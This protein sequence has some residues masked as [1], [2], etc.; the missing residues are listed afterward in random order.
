MCEPDKL[1]FDDDCGDGVRE[2]LRRSWDSSNWV[3]S[4]HLDVF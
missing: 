3:K 4:V 2:G 1:D